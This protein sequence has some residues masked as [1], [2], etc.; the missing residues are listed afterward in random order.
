[1]IEMLFSDVFNSKIVQ[2]ERELD[3]AGDMLEESWCVREFKV[4]VSGKSFFK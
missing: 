3:G 2:D 4:A 1:M